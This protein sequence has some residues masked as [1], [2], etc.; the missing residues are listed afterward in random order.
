M[1]LSWL[2]LFFD[3]LEVDVS[4]IREGNLEKWHCVSKER[5]LKI[6]GFGFRLCCYGLISAYYRYHSGEAGG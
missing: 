4:K 5:G 3:Q 6:C 2:L 1:S